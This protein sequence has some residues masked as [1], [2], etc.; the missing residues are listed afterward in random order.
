MSFVGFDTLMSLGDI[1][2]S[3]VVYLFIKRVWKMERRDL[4]EVINYNGGWGGME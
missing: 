1:L 4:E 2:F 3:A